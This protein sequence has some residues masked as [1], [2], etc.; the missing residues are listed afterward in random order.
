[1]VRSLLWFLGALGGGGCG[2]SASRPLG[3]SG[4]I[5]MNMIRSTSSTSIS[6][7]TLMS[8]LGPPLPPPTAIAIRNLLTPP[9]SA[10]LAADC[11]SAFS[12]QSANLDR[13]HRRH[14]RCQQPRRRICTWRAHPHGHRRSCWYGSQYDL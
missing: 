6:G 8:A 7:V 4:V 3:V 12:D 10:T 1:M 13:P 9:H 11:W 5:T 2:T 14:E